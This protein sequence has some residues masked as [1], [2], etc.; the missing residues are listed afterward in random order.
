MGCCLSLFA[1]VCL[2]FVVLVVVA[3]FAATAAALVVA[4]ARAPF[5]AVAVT[6]LAALGVGIADQAQTPFSLTQA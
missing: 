5:L 4:V 2:G 3:V 1:F 6:L